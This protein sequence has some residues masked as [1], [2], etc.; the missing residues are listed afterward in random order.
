[1]SLE[2]YQ[3]KLKESEAINKSLGAKVVCSSEIKFC[4]YI[5]ISREGSRG[6]IA[7]GP[8]AQRGLIAPNASRSKGPL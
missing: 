3:T 5:Q 1:M 7:P 4:C 8:Q 6:E 2:R